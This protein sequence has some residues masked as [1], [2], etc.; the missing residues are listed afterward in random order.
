MVYLV[1]Q[2]KMGGLR[3]IMNV[4]IQTHGQAIYS[5]NLKEHGTEY[6]LA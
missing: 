6:G 4:N 1:L 3:M 2:S 5:Q